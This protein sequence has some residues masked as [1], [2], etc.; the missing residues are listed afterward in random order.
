MLALN[1]DEANYRW[2]KKDASVGILL[3]NHKILWDKTKKAGYKG[4]PN[5]DT[6]ALYDDGRMEVYNNAEKTAQEFLDMGALHVLSF[7]PYLIRD[8]VLNEKR[9]RI[10]DGS[11]GVARI[12]IGQI[13]EGHYMAIMCEGRTKTSRGCNVWWL[14][15][16]MASRGCV[17]AF[18]LD[19]GRT[20][21]IEFMGKQICTVG[22]APVKG[23]YARKASELLY[24]GKSTLV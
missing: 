1:S 15:N 2:P 8:G 21:S 20:A 16:Q 3:R 18:N 10:Y 19:G 9:C 17:T 5:L 22:A 11:S 4:F 14:A 13:G 7:G 23:G 6:L 12:G 24:I